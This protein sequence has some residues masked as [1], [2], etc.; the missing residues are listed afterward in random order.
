MVSGISGG[1]GSASVGLAMLEAEQQLHREGKTFREATFEGSVTAEKVKSVYDGIQHAERD[2]QVTAG[3]VQAGI[4]AVGVGS[5]MVSTGL[6][7]KNFAKLTP[8]EKVNADAAANAEAMNP[9][10]ATTGSKVLAYGN[11]G[12]SAGLQVTQ[13]EL[14]EHD[15]I[16]QKWAEAFRQV[17]QEA[18]AVS[19]EV[20]G[21]VQRDR[22][23]GQELVDVLS[24]VQVPG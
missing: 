16:N 3:W 5:S 2:F 21:R 14:Q 6:A 12:V 19:N 20:A 7:Y 10:P 22:R 1:G 11:A 8:E 24:Q 17:D 9:K 23:L 13:Q 4:A 15:A 18:L